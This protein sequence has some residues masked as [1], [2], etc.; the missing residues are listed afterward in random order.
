MYESI[1]FLLSVIIDDNSLY[2]IKQSI[3]QLPEPIQHH[4]L[5]ISYIFYFNI[6]I[7]VK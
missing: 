6:N 3:D 7:T 4:I 2:K 1:N 5:Y